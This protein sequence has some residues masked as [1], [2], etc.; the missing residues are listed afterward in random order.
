MSG[1]VGIYN[2]DGRPV[3]QTNLQRMLDSIAH[4]GPDGSAT[5]TDGSVGFGHRMLW[6]TPESLHEKLPLTNKT[7]DITITADARIDNRDELIPTLNLNGRPRETIPDSEIILAAYEKWGEK[8]PEKLLGDFSFAI[9]DKWKQRIYCARDPIGIKPLYYYFKGGVF[10]WSSEPKAIFEDKAVSK[11]PNLPLICLYLLNRFDERE[12]T[13]YKDVYRLPA[14]QYMIVENGKIQKGKYWDINPNYTISHETDE[15]YTEHYLSLFKQAVRARLRSHSPVGVL[16]SG[17]LDSSSIVCT[18][19]VLYQEKSIPDRGFE[20]FSL[21]FDTLPCDE[22]IY[23][24]EVANKWSVRSNCFTYEDHVSSV[25][26]EQTYQ[27]SDIGYF[28]T[29]ISYRPVLSVAQQKG[30]RVMLNGIGGDDLLA[31]GFDHL[32]DLT[33]QG[34]IRKLIM[35]LRHDAELSSHSPYSLFL[36][37]CIKP[38]IPRPIKASIRQ[39]LKLFRGGEVPTWINPAYFR[40]VEADGRLNGIPSPP[41]FPTRSQQRIYEG[42]FYGWNADAIDMQER[43]SAH[44][45]IE[46]RYPFFDRRLVEF[47]LALPEEQRWHKERSKFI[48]RQAMRGV[49]PSL[50]QNRKDKAEFSPQVDWELKERQADKV[51]RLIHKSILGAL[52]LIDIDRFHMLFKEYQK[53]DTSY[54]IGDTIEIFVWLELWLRS[55]LGLYENG[56]KDV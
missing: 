20:T 36:N 35:Q 26:F 17:G 16:L 23:I 11:E 3:E 31:G 5:W 42:L 10:R 34:N 4:R 22:R 14:S 9:W 2:L 24:N 19:Q 28:P 27:Y 21:I 15:A 49:L 44:F 12:E 29:L 48:L 55:A 1:I 18:A 32:T 54:R 8:C 39:T 25:D 47:S 37:Y 30:I 51:E 46:D 43:F 7:G 33:F 53:S 6:T 52:G 56:G 50:V 38:L 13:L 45:A 40:K 41:K